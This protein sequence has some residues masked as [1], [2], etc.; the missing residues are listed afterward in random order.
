MQAVDLSQE[1][2]HS[3]LARHQ[4]KELLRFLTCGS[5][6]DG[7]S[8]VIGRLLH[9]TKTIYE[10]Q[11]AA[12][13]RDSEKVGTTGAG[14]VDLALLTDG[15]KA[16]REQGITIDVAYRYFST[17]RRK[18][19]IADTPGHEQYTRNMATGASTCQ[20]AIILIDA[21]HGV[22]TQTRRHSFIVSLL[23]IRHVVV[24][25]NKMDLVDYSRDVFERIKDDYTGFVAKLELRDITFIPMSALK[26]DN[27]VAKSDAMPW[28]AGP[29]LLDHLETVHI[30]SDRNMTDMRFPVQYVIRPN[31]DF[32]GFAG[33]V[34]S[35]IV[36]KG[37]EVVVLPSGT[38]TRVK[39]IV[40]YDGELEE[41]FAPQAVTVTLADEVDVSRGDMLV[42]PDSQPH[43]T[44][45]IEAMVVWMTE[46]PLVPGR[47]YT[48]KHTTRQVSAEVSAFRYGVDVNT[49][50]HREITRLGL[51]EVGHVQLSLT[52]ALACDP[53]S[54]NHATG[55]FILIDR[56]TNDTVGAGMILE[57]GGSR[58]PGDVWAS[59]PAARLKQ[60]G[61]L[62]EPAER[63]QRYHQVPVTVLLVGL[64]GSGKSR[65][66]FGLERRLWD[67]GR[68]VTVLYG[69][70]MRQGL[71]RDLGFTADDRSENLRRSAEVAKLLNDAGIITIAAFVAP[72]EAVRERTKQLIGR[73]RILEVYCTAPME[74]LRDRDQ[75]GAYRMADEGKIAQMPGVTAAFEEPKSPDLVLQTDQINVDECVDRIIELMKSR[76]CLP[77]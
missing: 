2:I 77:T 75:S 45:E 54:I 38:R 35:G 71:N 58:P 48:L 22:M 49:L 46:Q 21:R 68:A 56:L 62:V 50:E 74:V 55:A 13:K 51:N 5:V 11:L 31:L 30:A 57:A 61:S 10:D 67:E 32:R 33:T 47:S 63:E 59:E 40:T 20:L 43:L 27:I 44:S 65:I 18:F 41:A 60:R 9:D 14:E 12:V 52:R 29:P 64:T 1:D 73:D 19:I 16:E 53:Y 15:L 6:D 66:A 4:K 7:K 69:Q 3:Y 28:Y 42:R 23:G 34:A 76:G 17:D 39:S 72:H 24:A 25:V 36:R 8:T 26:G 70:N 37:D